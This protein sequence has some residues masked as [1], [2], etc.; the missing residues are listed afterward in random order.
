MSGADT[1]PQTGTPINKTSGTMPTQSANLNSSTQTSLS[2]PGLDLARM[3]GSSTNNGFWQAMLKSALDTIPQ[4][5]KENYSIWKDK[6]TALL[7]LGGVLTTLQSELTTPLASKENAELKLL[8]ISKMDSI[9]HNNIVTADNRGSAKLLWKAITK[10]FASSQASNQAWMFNK[11]LYVKFREDTIEAFV[12]D[13]KVAIKKLVDVGIDLPQD[14]LAYLILFK[15]PDNMQ[16][17]KRQIM[18]SDKDLSVEFVCNHLIQ[19]NNK[20]KAEMKELTSTPSYPASLYSNKPK[21]K[22]EKCSKHKEEKG[23]Q[24]SGPK[25]R[26]PNGYHNPKQDSNHLADL[27][28]QLHPE[29]APEWWQ[30]AQAK[31]LASKSTSYF[32]SLVTLW[33]ENRN[34]KS[35]IILDSGSSS[36]VFNNKHFFDKLELQNLDSIKTGKEGAN[37]PIK[38]IG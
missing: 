28:W 29:K 26:C 20:T 22:T 11:F 34:S 2:N 37:I 23:N 36:H 4:L 10:Q 13:T 27:C 24:Q 17:L 9:T 35:K 25:Q 38:G 30:E 32:M 3:L 1:G 15:L 18:H 6:I 5:T 16:I 7:G 19:F 8:I 31:W 21:S 33:I 14:I 12:T